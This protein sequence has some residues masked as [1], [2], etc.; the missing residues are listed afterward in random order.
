MQQEL[1]TCSGP[2]DWA[3]QASHHLMMVPAPPS[4]AHPSA[5]TRMR[6][7]SSTPGPVA[8]AAQPNHL[9]CLCCP[10]FTQPAL[11]AAAV[12]AMCR[13]WMV[14]PQRAVGPFALLRV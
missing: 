1:L 10:W 9:L 4:G 11:A 5:A 3:L 7:H 8:T 12:L 6:T 2:I 14:M 13:G